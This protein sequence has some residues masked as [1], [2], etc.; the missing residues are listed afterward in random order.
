MEFCY[1]QD[2]LDEIPVEIHSARKN[3]QITASFLQKKR[4]NQGAR[5]ARK[6]RQINL[7]RSG[8]KYWFSERVE[9]DLNL[10][11]IKLNK[12][13]H[14]FWLT[15]K[16]SF[17]QPMIRFFAMVDEFC[18]NIDHQKLRLTFIIFRFKSSSTLSEIQYLSLIGQG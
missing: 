14:N 16:K 4:L 13:K 2:F 11:M 12:S 17:L 18:K 9:E 7:V 8:K 15:N 5:E 1:P 3:R 6:I 10:K